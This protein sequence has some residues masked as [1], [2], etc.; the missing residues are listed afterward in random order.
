[1]L[2]ARI[3]STPSCSARTGR[4]I[5]ALEWSATPTARGQ[6]D[7]LLDLPLPKLVFP[8]P[9]ALLGL[10]DFVKRFYKKTLAEV[11]G[12]RFQAGFD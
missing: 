6:A 12:S 7:T 9:M 3:D 2:L 11:I 5:R 10:V 4:D 8:M 1:M